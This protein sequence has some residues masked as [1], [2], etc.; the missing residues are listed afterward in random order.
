M[1][2]HFARAV[3]TMFLQK[4]VDNLV[5]LNKRLRFEWQLLNYVLHYVFLHGL[6]YHHVL[7]LKAYNTIMCSF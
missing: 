7:L 2:I 3:V 6:Y 4:R 5:F 1:S